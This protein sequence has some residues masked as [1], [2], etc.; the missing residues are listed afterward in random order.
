MR[1]KR[2]IWQEMSSPYDTVTNMVTS[3]REECLR[4]LSGHPP[5]RLL[6]MAQVESV[7]THRRPCLIC[8]MCDILMIA[9]NLIQDDQ[10]VHKTHHLMFATFHLL[11]EIRSDLLC[12][13]ANWCWPCQHSLL[14]VTS[15]DMFH[16]MTICIAGSNKTYEIPVWRFSVDYIQSS[17]STF[18]FGFSQNTLGFLECMW[19]TVFVSV[20]YA[21]DK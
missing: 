14:T 10:R 6:G 1:L 13:N 17:V 9:G 8:V 15:S 2:L 3:C 4:L 21:S 7:G 12:F 5:C 20:R 19:P 16:N 11:T 18:L